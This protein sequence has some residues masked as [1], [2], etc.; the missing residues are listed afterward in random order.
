[1]SLFRKDGQKGFI[2]ISSYFVIFVLIILG[3][4]FAIRSVNESLVEKKQ[5]EATQAFHIAEAGL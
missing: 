1:M 3:A 5:R 4:V 2:L